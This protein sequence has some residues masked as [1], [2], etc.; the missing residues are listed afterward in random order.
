[1]KRKYICPTVCPTT[2]VS[3]L[4]LFLDVFD[5]NE[6][7]KITTELFSPKY[8]TY[9][10]ESYEELIHACAGP[11]CYP[12]E[13][14]LFQ[15]GAKY[16]HRDKSWK[17]SPPV[18]PERWGEICMQILVPEAWP[19]QSEKDVLLDYFRSFWREQHKQ[20]VHEK[21]QTRWK[22][23][24]FSESMQNLWSVWKE[25][26]PSFILQWLRSLEKKVNPSA[27]NAFGVAR[28]NFRTKSLFQKG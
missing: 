13:T 21:L 2:S 15:W 18:P 9:L 5:K 24:L 6:Q 19:A 26:Q 23:F 14:D 25:Q 4:F 12:M 3:D 10:Q 28:T 8:Q 16:F 22:T 1:M 7:R 20:Q 17:A 27:Y 11:L